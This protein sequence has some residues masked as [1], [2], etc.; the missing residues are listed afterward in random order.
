MKNTLLICSLLLFFGISKA[1]VITFTPSSSV[2][3][4]QVGYLYIDANN[5]G[6]NDFLMTAKARTS[7]DTS[8]FKIRSLT[9]G[10]KI[11]TDGTGKVSGLNQGVLISGQVPSN[12]WADS[13]W[14]KRWDGSPYPY[15][16]ATY[17]NMAFRFTAGAN[18]HYGY[19]TGYLTDVPQGMG[20][21]NYYIYRIG[22][23][24]TP[25]LGILANSD[26]SIVATPAPAIPS[27]SM[28]Q[29]RDM[30]RLDFERPVA[31]IVE[32]CDLQ[33]RVLMLHDVQ[34]ALCNVTTGSL[35]EGIYLLR[36]TSARNTG[37]P[38]VTKKFVLTR[39]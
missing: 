12:L 31:A 35:S 37:Q 20:F 16:S 17:S 22:Y 2:F 38:S 30:I 1:A 6:F 24:T 27:F 33:G 28:S 23:E 14:V 25:G 5:D 26:T 11:L 36:L 4:W 34:G 29:F 21:M 19:I 10:T 15:P 18:D 39:D 8:W 32:V 3:D 13:A 9:A 7:W